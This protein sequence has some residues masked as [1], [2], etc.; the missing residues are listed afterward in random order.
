MRPPRVGRNG[1]ALSDLAAERHSA[2]PSLPLC[3][4]LPR[5]GPRDRGQGAVPQTTP[6]HKEHPILQS[7]FARL[8]PI[9]L[10]ESTPNPKTALVSG[11]SLGPDR[12]CRAVAVPQQSVPQSSVPGSPLICSC[13]SLR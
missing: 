2:S 9:P 6:V 13:L 4:P 5:L 7:A 11:R 1:T 8:A 12:Q 10:T 3:R